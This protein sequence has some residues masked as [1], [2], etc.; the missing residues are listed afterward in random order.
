MT[1]QRRAVSNRSPLRIAFVGTGVMARNHL[2]ALGHVQT[3]H[4][5][6]GVFDLS[7]TA[8]AAFAQQAGPQATVYPTLAAL[9]AE[10]KPDV[11]HVCTPAGTHFEPARRAL[12]AGAHVYVE[13]PFV[14]TRVEADELFRLARERQ[15]LICAGHQL[16]R[17]RAFEM[18]LER[19]GAL[20]SITM[21]DSH[22]A[23]RSPTLSLH[24]SSDR[25]LAGQLLDVLPHP[26]YTLLAALE[27]VTPADSRPEIVAV[28]ATPVELHA[29]LRQGDVSGR[30]M[31]SLRAR[32]VA[33]TLALTGSGGTLTADFVSGMLLGAGNEGTS[34]LEKMGNPF[35][36]AAQLLWQNTASL[37]RR[38]L[39][40]GGYA[41]L[42]ELIDALYGAV[43]RGEA[44]SPL[45]SEHLSHVAAIY[46]ELAAA[47]R[48]TVSARRASPTRDTTR[49]PNGP[50]AVL[51]GASGFF[52]R[53]IAREL[54]Q[55]GFRVRG[56]GRSDRPEHGD[57]A[58]W[59]HA[60]LSRAV[61]AGALDDAAVVVHAAAETAG[62]MDAHQRNTVDVTKNL[63]SAMA[64]AR[65]RRIVL[66]SSISVLEPPRSAWEVQDEQTPLAKQ[67]ERLGAYTWGK[68]VAE[69]LVS[70]AHEAGTVEARIVRPG[71]LIDWEHIEL[72]GLVGRRLFGQ[73]HLAL[74][75]PGL[76]FAACEVGR[77]AGVIAW[78]AE[79]F[80]A[81]PPVLNLFDPAIATR[82]QLR[83]AFRTR[84]WRG[85]LVWVPISFIASALK[86][87]RLVLSLAH[88]QWPAPLAVWGILRP[89]R[90]AVERAASALHAA[91]ATTRER[92]LP[93]R[94]VTASQRRDVP[95][96]S[97]MT[98]T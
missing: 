22:F 74:G 35:V 41:G 18:L 73:W 54:T 72:P 5:V 48:P 42:T 17:D 3:G 90:Y 46:E 49:H 89:R 36:Q 88:G 29:L 61:P 84:G 85:R 43:A 91:V 83:D 66:V 81:A 64:T 2:G 53:A 52:G 37:V 6:T 92:H 13:K 31:I 47:V 34:P 55:R 19:A 12:L 67:S 96:V 95:S 86:T 32:P 56:I 69:Q 63:L 8:A 68:V 30:L 50:V 82:G 14:E 23:F 77:A 97:G 24:R 79:Q 38:I 93:P 51:T 28:S 7:A 58:E 25:A 45:P 15:L 21:V 98:R 33:S 27:H 94:V 57:I 59:I 80:G 11:V 10:S 39:R 40:G 20:G 75:R 70:A 16:T 87:A 9:L 65:V 71:A 78:S 4:R 26:L 76:P 62:G 60:D 1:N 44:Q